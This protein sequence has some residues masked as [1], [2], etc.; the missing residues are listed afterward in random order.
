MNERKEEKKISKVSQSTLKKE[1][2]SLKE[3]LDEYKTL[4]EKQKEEFQQAFQV[5]KR[6]SNRQKH[7]AIES[8]VIDL[9]PILDS[10]DEAIKLDQ[11]SSSSIKDGI[12]M[13]SKK[14]ES[15]LE[16]HGIITFGSVGDTFSPD[17]HEIFSKEVNIDYPPDTII[18]I[19]RKG[20]KL[21]N[22]IVRPA[23]VVLSNNN[24]CEH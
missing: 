22:T 1:I 23:L 14:L 6:E 13:V 18:K 10:L 8:I 9:I 19:L 16:K 17:Q 24:I 4:L 7:L 15:I 21:G 12:C 5:L 20:Y 2:D 11:T 3:S